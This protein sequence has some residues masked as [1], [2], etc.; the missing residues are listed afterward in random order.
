MW[1]RRYPNMISNV[2]LCLSATLQGAQ[3]FS[4]AVTFPHSLLP[5][6]RLKLDWG[7]GYN[8]IS[9]FPTAA[10]FHPLLSLL[11]FISVLIWDLGTFSITFNVLKSHLRGNEIHQQ[12]L[13]GWIIL[14]FITCIHIFAIQRNPFFRGM[15]DGT[16]PHSHSHSNMAPPSRSI[17]H[18]FIIL[19]QEGSGVEVWIWAFLRLIFA[20]FWV[21]KRPYFLRNGICLSPSCSK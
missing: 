16:L 5:L 13:W 14:D 7:N 15:A 18:L 8:T 21:G 20:P 3:L 2:F 11:S 9:F 4:A 12:L 10:L 6:R 19:T 17:R 1:V